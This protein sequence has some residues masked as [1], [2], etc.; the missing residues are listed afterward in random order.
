MRLKYEPASAAGSSCE[1]G[2]SKGL[3]FCFDWGVW[4]VGLLGVGCGVWSLEF[5]VEVS[6]V[7]G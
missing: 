3:G 5:R 4:G 6:G 2:R 1:E 7:G